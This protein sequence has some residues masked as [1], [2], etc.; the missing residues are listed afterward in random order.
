M[1]SKAE[2]LTARY[3]SLAKSDY[4]DSHK[5]QNVLPPSSRQYTD[6]H[7]KDWLPSSLPLQVYQYPQRDKT[8]PIKPLYA[9]S[10]RDG[11]LK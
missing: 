9:T 6:D 5:V 8:L 1:I 3:Q 4:D 10:I 2:M 7:G 11:F